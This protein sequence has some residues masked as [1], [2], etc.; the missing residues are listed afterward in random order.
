MAKSASLPQR[1]VT[2]VDIACAASELNPGIVGLYRGLVRMRRRLGSIRTQTKPEELVNTASF[3]SFL[4]S[5]I[6]L[7]RG[8]S[9]GH[10][11][12]FK[13]RDVVM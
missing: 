10:I 13:V 5:L 8:R 12:A 11:Y 2:G 4:E 6:S 7:D 9:V 1:I 3:L